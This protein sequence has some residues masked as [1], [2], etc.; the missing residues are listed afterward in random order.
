MERHHSLA[1]AIVYLAAS[2]ILIHDH[3][4]PH[5][6]CTLAAAAIYTAVWFAA[7]RAAVHVERMLARALA[8]L[9]RKFRR[10]GSGT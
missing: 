1:L 5:A 8:A 6:C 9:H 3:A 10:Q 7:S 2:A 4:L